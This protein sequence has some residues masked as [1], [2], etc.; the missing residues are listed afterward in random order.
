MTSPLLYKYVSIAGLRRIL[1]GSVRFTQP[2]AFNDPFELLPEI[3]VPA[4]E[5][6]RP[7][8]VSFDILADRR[9]QPDKAA[10]AIPDGCG[11][12]DAM[13]RDIVQQL[14]RLIGILSLSRTGNS[15]LMWSH[16]AD[17]YAGAVVA[18][19]GS[20]DFF[21]GQID[22]EYR[23]TRPRRHVQSYLA[24][25]PI[26]VAELCAKSDQWAYEREVRVIR[27]LE[28][29]E[30]SGTDVRG[31]PVFVRPIPVDAIK[32]VIL[33]ERT[34]VVEQ[35]E[36]F[37]RIMDTSIALSLAAIDHSGFAFREE[38]IKFGA[39]LSTMGPM[40]SPRTAHI[41][42]DLPSQRGEFARWLVDHHPM[43]KIVNRP[44]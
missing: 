6:E 9:V 44:T 2:S 27:P 11:C 3:I 25:T 5:Q 1:A 4:E 18:F 15:L 39:P 23:S 20:H 22:I 36:I 17:Q 32:S 14:N 7:I 34:P 13:S 28:E 29:C 37:A 33:G 30:A 10:E 24:G 40:M 26:P 16:Y 35:R 38:T 31:F 42:S 19:D 12:S 41:F 21:S 43:S 8:S